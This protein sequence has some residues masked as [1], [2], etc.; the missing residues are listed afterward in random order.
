M[1]RRMLCTAIL[2]AVMQGCWNAA[3]S[4]AQDQNGQM[5]QAEKKMGQTMMKDNGQQMMNDQKHPHRMSKKKHIRKKSQ[6]NSNE[7]KS[8]EP[9]RM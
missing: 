5:M 3:P 2:T 1:L 6:K 4:F 7:M 9:N 8:G